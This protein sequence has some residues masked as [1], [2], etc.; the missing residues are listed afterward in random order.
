MRPIVKVV[1]TIECDCKCGSWLQHWKNINPPLN[2][3]G[4]STIYCSAYN[5]ILGGLP[6]ATSV[7]FNNSDDVYIIPF[8][9]A[10]SKSEVE[11]LLYDSPKIANVNYRDVCDFKWSQE[12][13]KT[14]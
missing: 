6:I 3:I 14:T 5:C 8:C 12:H 7:R 2:H 1:E 11:I 10:H 13:S 9:E 4:Y